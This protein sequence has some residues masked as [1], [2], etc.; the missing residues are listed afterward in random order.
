MLGN[1]SHRTNE[2][3]KVF[4]TFE[5]KMTKEGKVKED[6]QTRMERKKREREQKEEEKRFR[7]E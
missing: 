7:E 3:S 4:S 5:P 2:T 1:R 6:E